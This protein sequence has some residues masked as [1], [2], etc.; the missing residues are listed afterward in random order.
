MIAIVGA[1]I[2]GL[3]LAWHLHQKNIPY[4][5]FES[6]GEIGGYLKTVQMGKNKAYL[7]ER[8]ANSLLMDNE[9][10]DFIKKTGFENE[11]IYANKVSKSRFIVRDKKPKKL[12][13]SPQGLLFGSFFS[14]QTKAKIFKELYYKKEELDPKITVGEF[15]ENHFGKEVVDYAVSPFVTGIYAADAYQLLLKYTFPILTE[16]AQAHGSILKGFIKNKSGDRKQSVSFKNGMQSFAKNISKNLNVQYNH[17]VISIQNSN[18]T[19]RKNRRWLLEIEHNNLG[20]IKIESLE[21]DKVFLTTSPSISADLLEPHFEKLA[22]TI[23]DIHYPT[24]CLIHSVFKKEDVDFDLNGFGAL[25]PKV[26]GLFSAGTIW[27]SSVFEGRAP[28]D[29][30]LFTGFVGG[31][32]WQEN[33]ELPKQEIL[34]RHTD[35]LKEIYGIKNDPVVQQFTRWD[36]SVPQYDEQLLQVEKQLKRLKKSDIYICANW[37]GGVSVADCIKKGRDLALQ[38]IADSNL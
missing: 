38:F 25:H 17:R 35:E 26:E 37:F 23:R 22:H 21:F 10:L 14:T 8:G 6:S 36:K 15:L 7:F 5:I 27:S 33:A 9:I 4:Q 19:E 32:Q 20:E 16:Y 31:R 18:F 28:E 2:S 24:M 13:S 29:E 30:V 11:L 3:S 34:K 12:P 1:G